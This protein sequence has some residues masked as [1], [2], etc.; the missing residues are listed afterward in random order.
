[1][2]VSPIQFKT[3]NLIQTVLSALA[4]SGL[5]AGRLEIEITES[6]LLEHDANTMATLHSLR[7][8]GA[9]IVMDDFG[10]GYSSLSYL[11]SFPFD[12]IKIDRSF[13]QDISKGGEAVAIVKAIISL[14]RS[15]N[16]GIVAEGV[17]TAE[18][19]EIL[20]AEQCTEI[21][22]YFFSPPRPADCINEIL[23]LCSERIQRAA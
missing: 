13:I 10:T 9:H 21:Q 6:V 3:R 7:S 5:A 12:K 11:R 19:L 4:G 14:A 16:I 23:A 20:R 22:G 18:Q 2:N 1:M 17:E 15:L 8:L